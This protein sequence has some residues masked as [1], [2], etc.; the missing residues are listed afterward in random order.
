MQDTSVVFQLLVLV[1]HIV[2]SFEGT[3]PVVLID[4]RP[5]PGGPELCVLR[6]AAPPPQLCRSGE[7]TGETRSALGG[8][9]EP[10]YSTGT[11]I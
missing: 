2:K 1:G 3:E 11:S 5:G 10:P 8:A 9:P 7:D 4:V 6:S